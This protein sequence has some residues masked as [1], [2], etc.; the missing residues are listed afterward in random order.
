[1]D[2]FVLSDLSGS[3]FQL[4]QKIIF[5]DPLVAGDLWNFQMYADQYVSSGYSAD[6]TIASG[7][8]NFTILAT[9]D[10]SF[11]KWAISGSITKQLTPQ[12]YLYNVH[13]INAQGDPNS[14]LTL[15]RGGINVVADISITGVSVDAK[16]PYHK[17]L[18]AVDA[19]ILSLLSDRVTEASFGG[20]T[21]ILQ[22]IEKLFKVRNEISD[23]V[24]E[25]DQE[26]RGNSRSRK[27]IT[28]FRNM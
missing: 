12:P 21:Y 17:M 4:N 14:R 24:A 9:E 27:I 2:D 1:M 8:I 16:T 11:Y 3:S 6:I 19:T 5:P 25:E 10:N 7:L 18:D 13:V 28:V 20:Q 15:E 23:R 22:D 26:L